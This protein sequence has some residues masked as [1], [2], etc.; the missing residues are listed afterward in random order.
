MTDRLIAIEAYW[1]PDNPD[2]AEDP[3]VMGEGGVHWMIAKIKQLRGLLQ[4]GMDI[5]DPNEVDDFDAE[6]RAA[7]NDDLL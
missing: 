6:V 3:D 1:Q 4:R 5:D 7:L 2:N